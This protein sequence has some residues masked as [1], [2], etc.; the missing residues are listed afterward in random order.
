M[1]CK[2]IREIYGDVP[3]AIGGLEASLR[4]FA[5]Y[6]YWDDCVRPSILVDSTANILMFGM[7]EHQITELAHRL[8]HGEDI[9]EI[10][11]VR[12]TCYL[13]EPCKHADRCGGMSV[14]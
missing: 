3:I 10:H 14:L 8:S 2:K 5:H 6:D 11:D 4:R 13:T 9:R 1:Y 7:G 12:G